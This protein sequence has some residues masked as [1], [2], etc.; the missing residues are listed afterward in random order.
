M[1]DS[2]LWVL[3]EILCTVFVFAICFSAAAGIRSK[4]LTAGFTNDYLKRWK[5]IKRYLH[6]EDVRYESRN[7]FTVSKDSKESPFDSFFC[8]LKFDLQSVPVSQQYV[9][10]LAVCELCELLTDETIVE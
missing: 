7:S 1:K 3:F 9:F 8:L 10:F 6:R 2:V 5:A 4:T